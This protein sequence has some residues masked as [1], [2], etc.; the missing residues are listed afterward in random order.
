MVSWEIVVKGCERAATADPC[1]RLACRWQ[2]SVA[3]RRAGGRA[4]G[5]APAAPSALTNNAKGAF[6]DALDLLVVGDGVQHGELIGIIRA[7]RSGGSAGGGSVVVGGR[8]LLVW[9]AA[10]LRSGS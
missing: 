7:C 9:C 1:A 3:R 8:R 4:D 6:P 2:P 5:L 10:A